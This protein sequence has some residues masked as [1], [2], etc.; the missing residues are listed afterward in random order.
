LSAAGITLHKIQQ[1]MT[2]TFRLY[3]SPTN[4]RLFAS[5]FCVI[6]F[7]HWPLPGGVYI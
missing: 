2:T 1:R 6:T 3:I 5:Q 4:S 7:V